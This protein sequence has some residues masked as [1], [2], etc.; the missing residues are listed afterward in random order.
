VHGI[1]RQ[2]ETPRRLAARG[3]AGAPGQDGYS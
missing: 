3:W 2:H 1:V